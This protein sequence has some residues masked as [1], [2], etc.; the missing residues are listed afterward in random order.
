MSSYR[1]PPDLDLPSLLGRRDGPETCPGVRAYGEGFLFCVREPG[2]D[3]RHHSE[4]GLAWSEFGGLL[5]RLPRVPRLD[6]EPP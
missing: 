2:H 4:K 5:I 1:D 3:G 6:Q